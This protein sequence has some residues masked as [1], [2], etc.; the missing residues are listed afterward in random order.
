MPAQTATGVRLVGGLFVPDL[1]DQL[2]TDP[3]SLDGQRPSDF[4]FPDDRALRDD[5]AE[6]YRNALDF[7]RIFQSRLAQLP[8]ADRA[9]SLTRNVW[10]VPLLSVLGYELERNERAYQLG[11][12]TYWI[13]HRAGSPSDAPPIHIAGARQDLGRVD[14]SGRPRRS[15]HA[16]VQ[17]FL[18][19]GGQLWGLVTNGRILRLLRTSP[20]LRTETYLE[21]DLEAIM[22]GERYGD[23]VVLYRLLH[24]TRL[25]T[26]LEDAPYCWLERYHQQGQE[27][28]ARARDRLRDGVERALLALGNGFLRHPANEALR[29]Q[30][31]AGELSASR[32]YEL[33]LRVVYRLLFLLVTE[34]RGLL[35]GNTIYW[36]GYSLTRLR[37]L[38]E[39]SARDDY[40]DLWDSLLA[41]FQV[42]R[43]STPQANGQPLAARLDLPVLDGD[44]FRAEPFEAWR[45][46]NRALLDALAGLS[47]LADEQGTVR[48]IN[49]AAL[50]VEELGSVYESLLDHA[51]VLDLAAS[52]PFSFVQGQGLERKS[53]G[54]YYTPPEL[55]RELVASS[56]EPVLAARLRG[57]KTKDE[58]EQAILS[59]KVCDPAAGSGHFLLAAARRLARELAQVRTGEQEPAPETVRDALRDVIAHCLYAV[60]KNPLAVELCKVALWIEAHVPEQPLTFLDHRIKCG[61]SLVGVFDLAVLRDGIP[62]EAYERDNAAEK[63]KASSIKRRNRQERAGQLTLTADVVAFDKTLLDLGRLTDHVAQMPE[64]TIAERRAKEQAYQQLQRDPRFRRLQ[65]ACDLWTAAFFADLRQSETVP[66]TDHVRQA[67]AGT[68]HDARLTGAAQALA[69]ELR[70]FHWP[71]AFPDVFAHGGFD[72]V[73]AN[74]P[75]ERVKLQEEEFFR[76]RAPQVASAPTAAE[77]KRRIAALADQDSALYAEYQQA[78]RAAQGQ[79]RFVRQSGRFPHGGR[80]DV[81]TYAVFTEL[82]WHMLAANGRAGLVVPTGIATDDTTKHL[83]GALV[84]ERA[85]VSLFG[86]QNREKLFPAVGSQVTFCLLTLAAGGHPEP[87]RFAFYLYRVDDLRDPERVFS[88]SPADFALINPNTHTCP[89][90]RSR[91]DAEITRA[92]YQR[93]PVLWRDATEN[94]SLVREVLHRLGTSPDVTKSTQLNPWGVEFLRMFDMANDSGL[95]RTRKELEAAGYRL[96]G[97]VFVRGEERYLPL[98]EAKLLHQFDHRWASYGGPGRWNA[99]PEGNG[100]PWLEQSARDWDDAVKLT[101]AAKADPEL[102]VLPRYWVAEREVEAKL[103]EKG[104]SRS[105]LLGWR[106]IARSTDERTLIASVI[107]RVAVGDTFLLMLPD[108]SRLE[109]VP[110]LL[111]N[112]DALPFDYVARQKVGGTHLKFNVTK[113]LPVLPPDVYAQ[114]CPWYPGQTLADWIRPRVLELVYT[115]WDLAPFARDLGDAG[116]PFR[117]DPERR[118]QLRAELDAAYFLLYGLSRSEVEY[119]LGTF[120]VL[121]QNEERAHGEYRTA[122]LVL[123]AYDVLVTAQTLGEPYRSPLQPP[124]GVRP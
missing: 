14:P 28:G 107:P 71:L 70:F 88:L 94:D 81:N 84:A 26:G 42:L 58:Q 40:D 60:D 98:Y 68:L 34:E 123:T 54:S 36:Q 16:L 32:Y 37:R 30:V 4:G 31:A 59:L 124:P 21:F 101:E 96:V 35:G 23:F 3:T 74:P 1:L 15:P 62:D 110:C 61:D 53:T 63:A 99:A 25:P 64:R 27:Q 76:V 67:L 52:E 17:E 97:N 44:L 78:L 72:V 51:P 56:L 80:G 66:T 85:L 20:R 105:W 10:I 120:P 41:L 121:R 113:Q 8:E 9:T 89:V 87:A 119:V 79:S 100:P 55:V 46:A 24:R 47:L 82:A 7:F 5:I 65:A 115:V 6:A 29:Q 48:R 77:R 114:P 92:V 18:N 122:R 112:L 86:F 103:A 2:R 91:R 95:F 33:L 102:V 108:I 83:F 57:K 22:A 12:E 50:D 11:E 38:V 93:V 116:P 104:W 117:W 43:D 111:A 13:S 118:A 75:W 19:R 106:D 69:S 45:L 90:F 73:L 39:E 49:Y 109:F